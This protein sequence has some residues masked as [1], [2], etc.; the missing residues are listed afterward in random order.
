[1]REHQLLR[2]VVGN[3]V[4]FELIGCLTSRPDCVSCYVW[5]RRRTLG[6]PRNRD[7]CLMQ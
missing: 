5:D 1:M 7:L 2:D 3:R 6:R 4:S